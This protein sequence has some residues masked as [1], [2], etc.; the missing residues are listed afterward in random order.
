[1]AYEALAIIQPENGLK[2]RAKGVNIWIDNWPTFSCKQQK[3]I[4][5]LRDAILHLDP[6]QTHSHPSSCRCM[7]MNVVIHER[8]SSYRDSCQLISKSMPC[9]RT[10]TDRRIRRSTRVRVHYR[11][12]KQVKKEKAQAPEENVKAVRIGHMYMWIVRGARDSRSPPSL[13]SLDGFSRALVLRFLSFYQREQSAQ[14][15][16]YMNLLLAM[17]LSQNG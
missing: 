5:L 2:T 1:M 9:R 12:E 17:H 16:G 13:S 10:M 7:H 15:L 3:A 4:C 14:N 6:D 8:T 11:W